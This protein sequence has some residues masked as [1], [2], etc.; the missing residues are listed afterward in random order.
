M[1]P[2]IKQGPPHL[3]Y[4]ILED[5]LGAG[6]FSVCK[7]AVHKATK[8]QFAIKIIDK[9]KRNPEVRAIQRRLVGE[10]VKPACPR[11]LSC[12]RRLMCITEP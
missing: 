3:E 10:L 8:A 6:T 2:K 4:E 11:M 1:H 12:L 7:R 9:T 5:V